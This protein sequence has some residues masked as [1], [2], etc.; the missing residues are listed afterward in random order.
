MIKQTVRINLRCPEH[1][2]ETGE[3][4]RA[5]C[6]TCCYLKAVRE[7][8][9]RLQGTIRAGVVEG[10]ATPQPKSASKGLEVE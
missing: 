8:L 2:R 1:P 9:L 10:L 7:D 6:G 5:S 4:P 3:N